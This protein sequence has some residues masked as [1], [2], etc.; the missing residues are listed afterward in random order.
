VVIGECPGFEFDS[1]ATFR[2]LRTFDFAESCGIEMINFEF[3]DYVEVPFDHPRVPRVK[4]ARAA[5]EADAIVNVPRMKS[6]K[7]TTLSLGIKNCF[8]MLEKSSRRKV[9]ALGLHQGIAALYK[10]FHPAFTLVDGLT[11]PADGAVY[12]QHVRLGAIAASE[13]ML[14]VDLVCSRLLGAHPA[15]IDHIRIAWGDRSIRPELV[16]DHIE[17]VT[18]GGL[19]D[20]RKRRAYRTIY[21]TVYAADHYLSRF[22]VQSTIPWF[23]CTFGIHPVVNWTKCNYC[24]ECEKVCPVDAIELKKSE[25]DYGRCG[26][27]RCLRCIDV[28]EPAAISVKQAFRST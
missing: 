10:L 16:G 18:V 12:G 27:M 6:H 1:A 7:L 26:R 4:I 15:D 13:D 14:S 11:I 20:T 23:H 28:C 22:G 17:P 3:D 8:G 21:R 24:G 19:E 2:Y 9:H 5:A 25:L